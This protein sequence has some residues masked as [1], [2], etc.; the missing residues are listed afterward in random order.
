MSLVRHVPDCLMMSDQKWLCVAQQPQKTNRVKEQ[1]APPKLSISECCC[2]CCSICMVSSRFIYHQRST[3]YT[4]HTICVF[5]VHLTNGPISCS[6]SS[7]CNQMSYYNHFQSAAGLHT[8]ESLR[9]CRHSHSQT[10]PAEFCMSH[11][12]DKPFSAQQTDTPEIA[13][14][15]KL[16]GVSQP[17]RC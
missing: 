10:A 7:P 12:L 4:E 17:H 5:L 9:H 1:F 6:C 16:L 13:H 2:Q 11:P 15:N 8:F 3:Q 14:S